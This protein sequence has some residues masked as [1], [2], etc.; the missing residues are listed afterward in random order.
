[1]RLKSYP[2]MHAALNALPPK[3]L[4]LSSD[5]PAQPIDLSTETLETRVAT[6]DNVSQGD[7]MV[8]LSA[9]KMETVVAAPIAGK[10]GGVTVKAGDDV[11]AGDLLVDLD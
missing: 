7:A 3:M 4:A 10:V 5:V 2:K 1:M 8:V 9:M 11:Q 6:G